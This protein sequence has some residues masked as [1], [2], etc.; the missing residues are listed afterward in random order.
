MWPTPIPPGP[1]EQSVW[2]YPRPPRLERVPE[3][4]RVVLAGRAIAETGA[5]YRVLETSHPPTYYFPP[6]DVVAGVL[7]PARRA[8]I[9][10]WKGR[11]VLYDVAAGGFRAE[12]AAWAYP[13]PTPDFTAITG[14]IAFYA[15]PME[16][17]FVG[18]A[19]VTPQPGGFY[20][21]WITPGIV[22]PF[23]GGPGTM[24]W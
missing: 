21:G 16:A 18:D 20:G 22:G 7:G 24:G 8:G 5:G 10:E 23:K 4:L 15:G 9:C 17:C 19:L 1:N 11:A 14:Y 13:D 3:R 12:G 6:G 2:D